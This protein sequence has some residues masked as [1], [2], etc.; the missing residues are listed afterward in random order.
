M[1][2]AHGGGDGHL[3]A[4]CDAAEALELV[5]EAFDLMV[6]LIEAPV[7]GRL[8]GSAG[9]GLDVRDRSKVACDEDAERI[10]VI[11]CIGD[12]VADALQACQ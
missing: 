10:G 8:G 2:E 11:G 12:D 3:A 1:N 9:I 7:D 5:E 4:Q 6:F